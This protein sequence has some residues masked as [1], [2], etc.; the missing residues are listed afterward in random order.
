MTPATIYDALIVGGSF[1]GLSAAMPL[2]RAAKKVCVLDSGQPRN[3]FAEASHGFFAQDGVAPLT[4]KAAGREKLAAYPTVDFVEGEAIRAQ[5][6]DDGFVVETLHG[7]RLYA[8]KLVLAFGI[9]DHLP[10]VPGL[11]ERW[12]GTVLHCPYCHGYEFL[13]QPLGVL[14]VTP[15]SVH[16][17]LL[18]SEWGPTTFFLNGGDR[19][20]AETLGHLKARGV[21]IEPA[22]IATLEGEAETLDGVRL[23]DGRVVPLAALYVATR[24]EMTSP[25]AEQLGC[26]IQDGMHGPLIVVDQIGQTSVPGVFAAGDIT[27]SMH[28]ASFA[29]ADGVMAGVAAHRSLV[30]GPLGL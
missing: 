20:D 4:L 18:I 26:I 21:Q 7:E 19:P 27:R 14:R 24:T 16:Q 15:M 12:G 23:S 3:R 1:A 6:S 30:F 5:R 2:A 10:D 9:R 13:N 28:N 17:A 22:P 11:A 25:L 29:A 8:R